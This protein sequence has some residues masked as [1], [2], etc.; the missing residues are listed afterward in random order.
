MI[1]Q[2]CVHQCEFVPVSQK[3]FM[4]VISIGGSRGLAVLPLHKGEPFSV[5]LLQTLA[6]CCP[7][8]GFGSPPQQGLQITTQLRA[9]REKQKRE[10]RGELKKERQSQANKRQ[11]QVKERP[12]ATTSRGDQAQGDAVTP[13]PPRSFKVAPYTPHK[14]MEDDKPCLADS[15]YM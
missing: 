10:C 1:I 12:E 6:R 11:P 2:H 3:L 5:Y 9:D 13:G 8:H 15:A 14:A 7:C 4:R